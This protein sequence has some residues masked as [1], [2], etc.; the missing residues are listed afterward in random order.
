[1]L[2]LLVGGCGVRDATSFR[3][4][5]QPVQHDDDLGCLGATTRDQELGVSVDL[6]HPVGEHTPGEVADDAR[7]GDLDV[8]QRIRRERLLIGVRDGAVGSGGPAAASPAPGSPAGAA[9][10]VRSP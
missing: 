6:G 3:A 1:M 7:E 4:A 5:A 9:V 2:S 8:H 10:P